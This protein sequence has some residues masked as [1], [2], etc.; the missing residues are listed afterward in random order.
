[1]HKL[2]S[3]LRTAYLVSMF[4]V[5]NGSE[6]KRSVGYSLKPDL[7]DKCWSQEQILQIF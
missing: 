4:L 1:M 7:K 6:I 3:L 5:I 2:I